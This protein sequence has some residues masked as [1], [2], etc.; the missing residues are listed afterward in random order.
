MAL[1]AQTPMSPRQHHQVWNNLSFSI[2]FFD[3]KT[4]SWK[5]QYRK[6]ELSA[7]KRLFG[8]FIS[9][10]YFDELFDLDHYPAT[11][12]L[13]ATNHTTPW[14]TIYK[15][16][17]DR[18]FDLLPYTETFVLDNN[19]WKI[20][21][22]NLNYFKQTYIRLT[23]QTNYENSLQIKIYKNSLGPHITLPNF[24]LCYKTLIP[25]L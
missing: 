14:N 22:I 4:E 16:F 1:P 5:T 24:S 2:A 13:F 21:S 18:T 9:N 3:T 20:H 7:K 23:G 25:A 10:L 19:Q 8:Q 11:F 12:M 17:Q 15:I 6:F